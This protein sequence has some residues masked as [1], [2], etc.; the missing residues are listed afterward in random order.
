M[1]RSYDTHTGL[2]AWFARNPVAA[3]LLMVIIVFG[4]LL[5]YGAM[6][7]QIFPDF[8]SNLV[9]VTVPY[10]GAAPQEVEEGVVV[11]VE[12][13]VADIK[14]IKAIR[15]TAREGAGVVTLE[16][17]SGYDVDQVL[18]EVKLRVDAIPNLPA[19]TEKPIIAKQE[20]QQ[21]VIWVSVYG[22]LDDRARK[23]F[24][25]RVRDELQAL[26]ELTDVAVVGSRAFEIAIEVSEVELRKFGLTFDEIARAVRQASIDLPGG[27]IRTEGGDIRLRSM[28]QVY[29]GAE[30]AGLVL[31][32]HA[33]GTRLTLGEVAEVKDGF[34]ETEGYARFDGKP[35]L[36]IRVSAVGS[37]NEIDIAA[38]VRRF[39]DT[40]RATLPEGIE[41]AYW[42]DRSFYLKGR[43]DMMMR[44]M[45][46][47]AVLVF[48]C[49][50]VFLRLTTAVWVIVGIPICFLGAF[51]LMPHVPWPATINMLSLFGF[52]LVLGIVVDDAIIIGES[53]YSETRKHG[54]SID[55]VIRGARRVAV[56]ATFG[57]LTTIAAFAPLLFVEGQAAVFFQAIAVVVILCLCFS[58]VES[59]LI[60]PAHLAHQ[61]GRQKS[62][63][64]AG[65]LTRYRRRFADGLERFV[66]RVYQPTLGVALRNL[67]TTLALFV[68]G[69]LVVIGL[70][71]GGAVRFVFF[72]DVPSDFIQVYLSLND[73]TAPAQRN[74]AIDRIERAVF[75]LDRDHRAATGEDLVRHL[76]LFTQ[77]DTGGQVVLELTKAE[78]RELDAFQI[79]DALRRR[80]GEIPGA[81]DLRF[82]ASTNPGGGPPIELHLR[83][84]DVDQLE[85][86][87]AELMAH[88]DGYDGVYD[89]NTS[90]NAGTREVRLSIRPEAETLGLSQA[91]L[92]R[93]VRQAFYG[94]EAQRILRGREDVRVMVRYPLEE[95]RSLA[96][97]TDMRIRTPDGDEVPFFEVADIALDVSYAAI[98]REDR[99]RTVTVTAYADTQRVEPGALVR[100]VREGFLKDLLDRYPTV[101]AGLGGASLEEQRMQRSLAIAAVSALFLIYALL[102]IPLKSYVQPLLIMS[103]IPFGVV[104]AVLGHILTGQNF[105]MMSMYGIIAL[106]GVVVNDSLILVDFVNRARA[107]GKELAE[108][109]VEAGGQ[110]FRPV[111]LTS[112]TTF[113]GLTP[114]LLERSLQAQFIIPMATS[115]GFGI[116]FATVITLFLIPALYASGA[117]LRA[118][119]RGSPAELQ[120]SAP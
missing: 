47:G 27:N 96:D 115:L 69:F 3:N 65:P 83:G 20:F 23:Q 118:R 59:K 4:G 91:D 79:T 41:L 114:I 106:S 66:E 62:D 90:I 99:Q 78:E 31:R 7:Q 1:V 14:G 21:S 34:V 60:L 100:E 42:G 108:A 48:L 67:G 2:I 11:R 26:P 89:V 6:R 53:A 5:S 38:A 98:Q 36:N 61:G 71:L 52:I 95:R 50:G 45:A 51:W 32:S 18:N 44:N 13:A 8:E 111:L 117:R 73:G 55:N 24:A 112:L 28:G 88:L 116:L 77:G 30:F 15:S 107:E 87:A 57:V 39:V 17:A 74:A 94:E 22:D 25:D 35:A 86:V 85:H 119:L 81:K 10:L 12:E 92:G 80:V 76:A 97:L 101:H 37:E 72:P 68:A 46:I 113:L 110:R 105:S 109:I 75:E 84:S 70:L 29:S 43:L 40:R 120:A 9:R 54:Q 49:L 103:V 58:L 63:A 64:E 19:Q 56:P 82:V 93:Q 33:D 16:V 102:A 104:G